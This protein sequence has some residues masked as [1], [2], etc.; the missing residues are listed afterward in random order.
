MNFYNFTVHIKNGILCL[1][2]TFLLLLAGCEKDI[3]LDIEEF[4][5]SN[6]NKILTIAQAK[7]WWDAN[8]SINFRSEENDTILTALNV[9]PLW[10][11]ALFTKYLGS[12]D[13]ILVPFSWQHPISMNERGKLMLVFFHGLETQQIHV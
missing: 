4:S 8:N 5:H 9:R 11:G 1:F 7:K 6:D 10:D 12:E 3:V 13:I 2:A